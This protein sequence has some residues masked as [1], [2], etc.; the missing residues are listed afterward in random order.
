M[1]KLSQ[2]EEVEGQADAGHHDHRQDE[3]RDRSERRAEIELAEEQVTAGAQAVEDV[4]AEQGKGA[5]A[6]VD[7]AGSPV[8]QDDPERN[9]GDQGSGAEAEQDEQEDVARG[10]LREAEKR[11]EVHALP[12]R[13]APVW[14]AV[15]PPPTHNASWAC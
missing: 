8:V 6:D 3:R 15:V 9:T 5:H 1:A 4:R 10:D 2:H 7:D 12:P 13:R 11:R 14:R